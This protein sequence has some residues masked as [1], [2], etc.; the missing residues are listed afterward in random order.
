MSEVIEIQS[1]G[2]SLPKSPIYVSESDARSDVAD[3]AP[4]PPPPQPTQKSA[5]SSIPPLPEL[6]DLVPNDIADAIAVEIK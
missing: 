6:P 2:G 4:T 5:P 1:D 3:G